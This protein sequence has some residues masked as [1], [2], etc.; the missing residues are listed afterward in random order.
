MDFTDLTLDRLLADFRNI[1]YTHQISVHPHYSEF[2][3]FFSSKDVLV[4]NDVVV[5]AHMVYG[6]MPTMLRLKTDEIDEILKLL[7]GIKN[8]GRTTL[9][10]LDL[11]RA[12][13]NN[14]M[15]GP[16]KLLHFIN[17]EMYAIW[18][19]RI[20]RYITGAIDQPKISKAINYLDYLQHI[21]SLV[22]E[23]GFSHIHDCV[24]SEMKVS[25]S[26]LRTAEIVMFETDKLNILRVI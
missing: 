21:N 13:M 18:D 1:D 4:Y 16:S 24:Q 15:V 14:S 26:K 8:G 5:A 17:P 2:L 12:M 25:H 9:T 11:I 20:F 22:L 19:S 23:P 6:R 3:G 7:N 10:D